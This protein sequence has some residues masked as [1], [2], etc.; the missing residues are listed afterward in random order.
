MEVLHKNKLFT[1]SQYG[2]EMVGFLIFIL[3][4]IITTI[5]Y[6]QVTYLNVLVFAWFRS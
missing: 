2:F 3:I 5:N 1:I 4:Q 6:I